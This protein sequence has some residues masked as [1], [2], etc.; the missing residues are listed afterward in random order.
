MRRLLGILAFLA[1]AVTAAAQTFEMS[2]PNLVAADEQ[3]NVTFKIDGDKAPSDFEWNPGDDFKLVW[4]PQKG[5]SSSVSIVNGKTTRQST[6][7]YTYVLMP[8]STGTF[9]LPPATATI[10]GKKISST[11]RAIQVVGGGQQQGNQSRSNSANA[12]ATSGEVSAEDI[13]LRMTLSKNSAVVG[14]GIT[15]TLRLYTRMKVAGFEDARFPTF[16]GF[17]SQQ[18]QAP[19]SI[20]FEREN[21]GGQI[22][23][24]AVIRSWTLIP[25]K[26]GAITIDPAELVCLVNVR[27]SSSGNSIFDSFFDSGYATIRKRVH[28]PSVQVRVA[29]LPAGAPA[30]FCGG[31]GKFSVKASLSRD[32]L[33]THDASSLLVTVSGTGNLALLEAPKISFPPDFEVYDVK[34]ADIR[35]GKTFEYPFI[36]RSHGDFVIGPVE[37]S[38]YDPSQGRY[39]TLRT[40]EMPLAVERNALASSAPAVSEGGVLSV[41]KKDVKDLGSD[42]RFISTRIPSFARPGAFLV[43]SPLFWGITGGLVL[44]AL[45]LWL[46][47]RR[48][49]ALKAD[50]ARTRNRGAVKMARRRLAAAGKYLQ[51]NLDTA[52]WE[53]LHRALLGFVAD[54][55]GMDAAD[56]SRENINRKL[57]DADASEAVAEEF[58]RLLD[59]CEYAR[60]APAAGQ[61]AMSAKYDKAVA[62]VSEIDSSMKKKPSARGAL[63]VLAMLLL[64]WAAT[65]ASLPDPA[66]SCP[67]PTGHLTAN[68]DSLWTAGV[69][70]YTSADYSSAREAWQ[71]IETQGLASPELFTNIGDAFYKADDY[72]RAILYYERALK[73]DPSFADARHNLALANSLVQDRI[74]SVPEFFLKGWLR[75]LGW[76]L[77]PDLWAVLFMVLLAGALALGLLFLLGRSPGARKAGFFAGIALLLL[78]LAALGFASWQRSEYSRSDSA[79]ITTPVVPVRSVPGAGDGKDLF[80]LHEGAKVRVMDTVSGWANIELSDGRQGWLREDNLEKV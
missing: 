13:F 7:T 33:K 35:G 44:L 76:K 79:I 65:S 43:W 36:P 40:K 1:F 51:E 9:S 63:A 59:D 23:D 60:Y 42:I 71:A 14:E 38:Y 11:P 56:M 24:A 26:S 31:V 18:L 78:S 75:S 5:T 67:A 27:K 48:R 10:R 17:W 80:I 4:G 54:K 69:D 21:V 73:L 3:F 66:S 39:V 41:E 16:G 29:A 61:E 70:A 68:P 53:E 6:T 22:Y 72:A 55:L 45:G 52:F 62:V 57:Q 74:E 49:A 37:Y 50:V 77:S 28:T 32:S 12:S 30:S 47:L 58:C 25:Q 34:T 2:A 20:Q 64:P 46:G 19:S 15:A 8:R